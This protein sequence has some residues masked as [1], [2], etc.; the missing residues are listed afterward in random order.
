[1]AAVLALL[2]SG[3]WGTADFLGG[4][5]TKR[6]PALAVYLGGQVFGFVFV[7][8]VMVV[9]QAWLDPSGYLWWGVATG[10][11]G[12]IAMMA[13]YNALATAPMGLIAP[14]VAL[15]VVIPVAWALLRGETPSAP[16]F[17]GIG[18][19][20]AGVLLASGPEL[21]AAPSARPLILAGIATLGFGAMYITM[22]EGSHASPT[23]TMV[24]FRC[25]SMVILVGVV[26]VTR[27]VGGLTR[28]DIPILAAIG[29][30]DGAAN[31]MFGFAITMGLMST[32]TVLS[33]LYPV[34]TAILAAVVLRERL[35]AVQ[36]V[37]VV[38]TMSGV[39]LISAMG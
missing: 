12:V 10:L 26:L 27:S 28:G 19:A 7:L 25:T 21:S 8:A 29:V 15:S 11:I 22:A 38:V 34:V 16:Q 3:I 30:G 35:R 14:M 18:L 39:L 23:M 1:M 32:T 4:M 2:S 20:I 36:Y 33:S 31:L 6:R 24:T 37:G 17:I 13:F 9:R 5:A